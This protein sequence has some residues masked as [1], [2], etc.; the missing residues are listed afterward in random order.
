MVHHRKF[1]Q[2]SVAEGKVLM[3]DPIASGCYL[4]GFAQYDE[5]VVRCATVATI[6][7]HISDAFLLDLLEDDRVTK[8]FS[9]L[10]EALRN[11]M[12]WL[13]GVTDTHV[14]NTG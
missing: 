6:V 2:E 13:P 4:A 8:R 3:D 10:E 14:G 12:E 11:E 5:D 9:K 7:T 1:L